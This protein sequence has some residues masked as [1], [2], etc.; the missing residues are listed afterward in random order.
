M[1]VVMCWLRLGLKALALAWLWVAQVSPNLELG[2]K[3]K[4]G[5]GPAWLWPR[6]GLM[7]LKLKQIY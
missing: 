6:P 5:L 2:Q 1:A 4:G 7:T 3:P